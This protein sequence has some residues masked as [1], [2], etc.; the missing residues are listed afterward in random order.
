MQNAVESFGIDWEELPD[1]YTVEA[2]EVQK[3]SALVWMLTWHY[4]NKTSIQ[5]HAVMTMVYRCAKLHFRL[6]R[7]CVG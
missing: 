2:V 6:K 3:L 5:L 7:F 4:Y 1:E